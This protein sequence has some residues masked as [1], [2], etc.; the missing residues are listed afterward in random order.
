MYEPPA[1]FRLPPNAAPQR[2]EQWWWQM[3][4]WLADQLDQQNI[5]A[6]RTANANP[7]RLK[8]LTE[9]ERAIA[10]ARNGKPEALRKLYPQFADCICAPKQ[11]RGRKKKQNKTPLKIAY[12][13]AVRIRA[14]WQKQYG[15]QNR[16]MRDDHKISADAFAAALCNEW[17]GCSLTT[18]DV[19]NYKPSGKHKQPRRKKFRAN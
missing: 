11:R 8:R 9:E 1:E 15:Q 7:W 16:S 3:Y 12:D 19:L 18:D 14:L 10:A 5:A 2:Q 17:F 6:M 4:D 13:F